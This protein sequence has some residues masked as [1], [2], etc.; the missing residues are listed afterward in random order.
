MPTSVHPD[1]FGRSFLNGAFIKY[2][3]NGRNGHNLG[4]IL[5]KLKIKFPP[6]FCLFDRPSERSL[7]RSSPARGSLERSRSVEQC[8][9]KNRIKVVIV[10]VVVRLLSNVNETARRTNACNAAI[11]RERERE[12]TS[13]LVRERNSSLG[14]GDG[15]VISNVCVTFSRSLASRARSRVLA[16]TVFI[17]RHRSFG[18][19]AALLTPVSRRQAEQISG[20]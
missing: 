5:S 1:I 20:G 19:S 12:R 11:T 6:Y 17:S 13:T 14:L 18:V 9:E 7:T 3:T 8:D 10:V 16:A 4:G 2:V 15:H